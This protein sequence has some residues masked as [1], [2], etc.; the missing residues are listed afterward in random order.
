MGAG[1]AVAAVGGAAWA[2]RAGMGSMGDYGDAVAAMRRRPTTA[3]ET[4]DHHMFVSLGC[5][6]ENLALAAGAAGRAGAID[7]DPAGG[8]Q[9][10]PLRD[11]QRRRSGAV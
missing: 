8:G 9:M 5:A 4:D 11:W 7:F 10:L 3:P 2:N 1:S 6:A